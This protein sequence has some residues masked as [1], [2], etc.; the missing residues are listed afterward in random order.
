MDFQKTKNIETNSF[1]SGMN[2]DLDP[3]LIKDGLYSHAINSALNSQNGS[4]P[5]IQNEQGTSLCINIPYTYNGSIPLKDNRFAIFSTDNTSSEIGIFD[6]SSCTYKKLVNSKCLGFNTNYII[7][8][9][10]KQNGDCT[11]SI[12]WCNNYNNNRTLNID[13]IPYTYTFADDDCKTKEYTTELDCNELELNSLIKIPCITINKSNVTGSIQNG[14]YQA[15]ITYSVKEQTITDFYGVTTPVSIFS[16]ENLG[17]A[18]DIELSNLDTDFP[19]YNLHIIATVAQ[20]T[21]VYKVGTYSTTQ[22]KVTVSQIRPTDITI[23]LSQVFLQKIV[24]SKSENVVV[25]NN[26]LIWI[27]PTTKPELDY[28]KLANKIK[29]SWVAYAVPV[30]DKN[31]DIQAYMRDEVYALSI[32]WNYTDSS[33]TYKY[34]L[35]GREA[36]KKELEITNTEDAFELTLNNCD[37]KTELR[38][39]QIYNTA[40]GFVSSSPVDKCEYKII[41][42]GEFGYYESLEKYPDNINT[43]EDL[44]CTP[45]RLF[46]FPDDSLVP[47]VLKDSSGN[48]T[49]IIHLGISISD[50][51]HPIDINGDK[52]TNIQGFEI[53][54]G[55][56]TTEKSILGKGLLFNM[57]QYDAKD[58][59]KML[60]PNYPY[61]DLNTDKFLSKTQTKG[62]TSKEK[63]YT[64]FGSFSDKY[65]TLHSPSFSFNKPSFGNELKIEGIESGNVQGKYESVYNH[66]KNKLLTDVAF[67]TSILLGLGEAYL[68]TR[69]KVI[70]TTITS[71]LSP[72]AAGSTVPGAGAAY[73]AAL[74]LYEKEVEAAKKASAWD[75]TGVT[76]KGLMIPIKAGLMTAATTAAAVGAA[77]VTVSETKEE[78]VVSSI[79]KVLKFL[80]GLVLFSHY[81]QQGVNTSLNLIRE[82]SKFEQYAYQVNSYC[83]YSEFKPSLNGKKRRYIEDISYLYPTVQQFGD[84][85]VNNFRRESSVVLKLSKSLSN[86]SIKD[87]SRQTMSQAGACDSKEYGAQASSYYVSIK[88]SK[89]S[90]YGQIQNIQWLNTGYCNSIEN[91]SKPENKY[92]ADLILGGDTFINRFTVKRKMHYFNQTAFGESDGFEFDYRKYINVPYPRYWADT[93]EY[94]L[95]E[96][97]SLTPKVPDDKS[98]LDCGTGKKLKDLLK[99]S[100]TVKDKYFYLSNNGIIDFYVESEINL[101]NR[102]W[103][104]QPFYRHYDEKKYSDVSTL[105]RADNLEYDN[106]YIYDKSY[107]KELTESVG[108]T[109][110]IYYD[111]NK[112]NTCY[113]KFTNRVFWSLP[114]NK[115]LL[116]DNWRTYL[117]NNYYEFPLDNGNLTGVKVLDRTNIVFLFDKSGPYMHQAIDQITTNA[118][119]KVTIGDGGLFDRQPQPI[120]TTD[121]NYG[122]SNS[123]FAHTTSPYGVLYP[124]A[125]N[126][127]VFLLQGTNLN[128]ISREGMQYWFQNNM[129]FNILKTHPNYLHKDNTITG[130]GYQTVYDN[131]NEVY[132]LTKIDYKVKDEYKNSVFYDEDKDYFYLKVGNGKRVIVFKEPLYFEDCSWTISYMPKMKCWVS[133]HDWHPNSI[134]QTEKHFI[135]ITNPTKARKCSLWK[136]NERCDKF[137][138]Y[139]DTQYSWDIEYIIN[140]GQN[141]SILSNIEYILESYVY[142]TNCIS[143]HHLLDYNFNRAYISNTEQQSGLLK[144]NIATKNKISM[145]LQYPKINSDSIDIEYHKEEQK[146]RF[147]QFWDIAKNRAEFN[148]AYISTYLYESN[149]YRYTPNPAYVNYAKPPFERKK[150]RHNW[151]KVYLSR[152]NEQDEVMPHMIMKFSNSKNLIS[153]R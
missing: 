112:A 56:R 135:G 69:E 40:S 71:S 147:N 86:P 44:S 76:L 41:G 151:H 138:N 97:V 73:S 99:S 141:T 148:N 30:E 78:T 31:F 17:S 150:L 55:D 37:K 149:G 65:Y 5:S 8:G 142:D 88:Q 145:V 26:Q 133:F 108:F 82:F 140:N 62:T 95:G 20:Q 43:Y 3:Q 114:N 74:I 96:L 87:S 85:T 77:T 18:L 123:R 49:H 100:F 75:L 136:H 93:E 92:S 153:P 111:P 113:T 29:A 67:I 33:K 79:P 131:T 38:R 47:R 57:G 105:L 22:T 21:T 134:I 45:I 48:V 11:E 109:Q 106:R 80:N 126:G 46:R 120:I 59:T 35:I 110:N 52:L 27:S 146:F 137:C 91:P 58:G 12:Y 24:N 13:N 130:I 72:I 94:D 50:I 118:G 129:D 32:G 9:V 7:R 51:E 61:N 16:H 6:E 128:E 127:R 152:E 4:F 90:Q 14:A 139:Y 84:K 63:G 42:T 122:S 144:L 19:E 124:S 125:T 2:K 81:F 10:S 102:D 119:L 68:A 83:K 70:L 117:A 53:Y 116:K 28:Q 121:V 143:K 89:P 1:S 64:P 23:P 25:S 132:Y 66:P 103:E 36:T 104:E 39:W 34:P 15:V 107:S 60:Y 115:D 54:R 98:H 101:A